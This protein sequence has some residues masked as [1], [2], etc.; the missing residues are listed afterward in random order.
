METFN[1][2]SIFPLKIKINIF[3]NIVA[4]KNIFRMTSD[5]LFVNVNNLLISVKEIVFNVI[6][7]Y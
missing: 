7:D 5:L 2:V 1:S 3:V 6:Y 4:C